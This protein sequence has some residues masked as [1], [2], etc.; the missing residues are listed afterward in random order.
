M[1]HVELS[2]ATLC[3]AGPGPH[4]GGFSYINERQRNSL[5]LSALYFFSYQRYY[6]H[7]SEN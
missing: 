7:L 4:L 5:L 1:H 2:A 6:G 3:S